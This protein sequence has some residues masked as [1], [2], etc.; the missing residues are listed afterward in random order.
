MNFTLCFIVSGYNSYEGSGGGCGDDPYSDDED[1][2]DSDGRMDYYDGEGS[3]SGDGEYYDHED[4]E[5]YDA[6]DDDDTVP[7]PPWI[8]P[9]PSEKDDDDG[10]LH[11]ELWGG[12]DHLPQVV[13]ESPTGGQLYLFPHQVA[14]SIPLLRGDLGELCKPA[15]HR[16]LEVYQKMQTECPAIAAFAPAYLGKVVIDVMHILSNQAC[17]RGPLQVMQYA[18]H[19][20]QQEAFRGVGKRLRT[21][22]EV[23]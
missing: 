20:A 9:G 21:V 13:A 2:Y 5:A 22:M 23:R 16:E 10:Q 15:S 7:W 11:E 4:S 18:D 14:G 8:K 6:D 1:C 17:L 12:V 19:E 3:G